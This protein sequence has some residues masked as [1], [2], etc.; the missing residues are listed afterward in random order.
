MGQYR[1]IVGNGSPVVIMIEEASS[2]ESI[3]LGW[4]WIPG[5]LTVKGLQIRTLYMR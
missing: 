3:P 5:L 4:E 2:K 1:N